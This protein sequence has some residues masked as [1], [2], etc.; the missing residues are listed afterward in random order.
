MRAP[1]TG[2]LSESHGST[3]ADSPKMLV[4]VP[5]RRQAPP[6]SHLEVSGASPPEYV[7]IGDLPVVDSRRS[8]AIP[9]IGTAGSTSSAAVQHDAHP[10]HL[11]AGPLLGPRAPSGN[12]RHS[13]KAPLFR[14]KGRRYHQGN[15]MRAILTI[16]LICGL[17]AQPLSLLRGWTCEC[18]AAAT[19]TASATYADA[20]AGDP[21][22]AGRADEPTRGDRNAPSDSDRDDGHEGCPMPCCTGTPPI[23]LDSPP[24]GGLPVRDPVCLV[25]ATA[26]SYP[27]APSSRLKRPPRAPALA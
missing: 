7:G 16:T 24:E 8:V 2:G 13:P 27:D 18:C 11:W 1:T 26:T 17:L 12:G 10:L 19:P 22:C 25:E 6:N 14:P 4:S 3:T 9:A 5:A 15:H 23:A 20:P 21:C